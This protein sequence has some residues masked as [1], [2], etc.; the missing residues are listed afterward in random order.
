M[1]N[2]KITLASFILACSLASFIFLGSLQSNYSFQ[3]KA[4]KI[5]DKVENAVKA[6]PTSLP[7]VSI[8]QKIFNTLT[9]II[10]AI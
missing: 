8:L 2:K 3:A 7:D 5:N 9:D 4:L 10:K 1:K 6:A